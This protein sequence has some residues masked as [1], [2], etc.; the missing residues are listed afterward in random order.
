MI[1]ANARLIFPDGICEGRN[2]DLQSVRVA[3]LYSAESDRAGKMSADRTGKM[4]VFRTGTATR[5][6]KLLRP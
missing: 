5:V 3:E 1:F 4:P 2:T 6:A